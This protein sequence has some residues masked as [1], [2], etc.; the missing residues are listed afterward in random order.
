LEELG[1]EYEIKRYG[2]DKQT[3]L[4]PPELTEIHPLG[5]APQ[6]SSTL[7]THTMTA[8]CVP[9]KERRHGAC[10]RIGCTTRRAHSC[11]S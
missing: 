11:P 5:K 7:C 10:T 9:R 2:R 6:L 4:A 1:V 3:S 8:S